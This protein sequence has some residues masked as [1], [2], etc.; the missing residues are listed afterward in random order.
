M[1]SSSICKITEFEIQTRAIGCIIEEALL[2]GFNVERNLSAF[3]P[4]KKGHNKKM[5]IKMRWLEGSTV[6]TLHKI[7]QRC[8][9]TH[10]D[11]ILG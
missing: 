8:K 4:N 3:C 6:V 7:R 11:D 1:G 9:G 5:A 10:L 2:R